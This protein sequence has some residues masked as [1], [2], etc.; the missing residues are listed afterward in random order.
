[1]SDWQ[2]IETAPRD[3][4]HFLAYYTDLVD[5]YDEN[6]RLVARG[7][8]TPNCGIAYQVEWLGGIVDYPFAGRI[9]Q[10][11]RYTHWMPLPPAPAQPTPREGKA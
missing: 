2:P 7:V 10:T 8:V 4:T 11:R 3:G 9:Y 1:M 6:D 5:E